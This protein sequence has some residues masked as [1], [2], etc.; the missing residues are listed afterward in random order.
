MH[1][2]SKKF[3]WIYKL[4]RGGL[5]RALSQNKS[6]GSLIFIVLASV[7]QWAT[8][9]RLRTVVTIVQG[10]KENIVFTDFQASESSKDMPFASFA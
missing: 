7:F 10:T 2:G 6:P 3:W 1:T 4:S 9:V 5:Y 8:F